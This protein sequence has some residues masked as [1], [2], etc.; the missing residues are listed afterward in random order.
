MTPMKLR[1]HVETVQFSEVSCSAPEI[2][3]GSAQDFLKITVASGPKQS[4]QIKKLDGA[5]H[6]LANTPLIPA[7]ESYVW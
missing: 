7:G 6:I 2:Q 5:E 4:F 1:R 3:L